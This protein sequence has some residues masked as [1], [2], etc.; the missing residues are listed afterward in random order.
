MKFAIDY[1][2]LS[3]HKTILIDVF[4]RELTGNSKGLISD[5]QE[6]DTH[7]V[8]L[9]N[10][11]SKILVIDPSNPQFSSPLA[12]FNKAL[13]EVSYSANDKYKIYQPPEKASEKGLIGKNVYQW[14]DCIDVA[15]KL[16]FGLNNE[17]EN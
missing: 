8:V 9:Y 11:G 7:T 15:V 17:D 2:K 10:T 3:E 1:L 14:R 12:N 4:K 5:L 16:A 13:I 6:L